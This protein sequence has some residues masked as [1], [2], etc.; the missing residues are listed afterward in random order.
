MVSQGAL[1]TNDDVEAYF[2][3]TISLAPKN[4]NNG[5]YFIPSPIFS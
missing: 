5:N 1:F 4:Q 3:P 2:I